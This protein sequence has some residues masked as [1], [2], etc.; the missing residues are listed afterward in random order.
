MDLRNCNRIFV[1]INNRTEHVNEGFDIDLFQDN[2]SP[3]PS[4]AP[5]SPSSSSSSST[6]GN[7]IT[8]DTFNTV[9]LN[10]PN[11]TEHYLSGS[12]RVQNNDSPER[13]PI[14]S[15][16][17]YRGSDLTFQDALLIIEMIKSTNNF[18]DTNES[19]I[20]GMLGSFMP[21]D[22]LIRQIMSE[23]SG[24]IY[25]FQNLMKKAQVHFQK[26]SVH[27][28]FVCNK[29]CK[30]FAGTNEMLNSCSICNSVFDILDKN[31]KHL[32]YMPLKDRLIS[33]LLSDLKNMFYYPVLRSKTDA[34]FIQ[35]LYDGSIWKHFESQMDT[36]NGQK[37]IG[38]QWCWD[39]ADAFTF[40]GK[41]F[42]PG[43]FS[44]LNFPKDL[45]GKLHVGMHVTT[46]CAGNLYVQL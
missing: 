29:G 15:Q 3:V 11:L 28:I 37:L 41:S 39:G 40:S 18:G 10:N 16:P 43:C 1:S 42:W 6:S 7:D 5:S 45:R 8:P 21:K 36:A 25:H 13:D 19:I 33:L 26:S 31:T 9:I 12:V 23:K 35:D 17:L 30:A 20:L 34:N 24:S 2:N 38:L 14:F 27:K 32:Y 4:S 44:I 22:N 46:L